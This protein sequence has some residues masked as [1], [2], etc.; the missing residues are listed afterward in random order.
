M[1]TLLTVLS[2]FGAVFALVLGF[3][4]ITAGWE[5]PWP[6]VTQ[7]GYRGVQLQQLDN[8]ANHGGLIA[9]KGYR[10]LWSLPLRQI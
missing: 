10:R 2:A 6:K 1:K 3:G 4:V 5:R 8:R 7:L 9:M